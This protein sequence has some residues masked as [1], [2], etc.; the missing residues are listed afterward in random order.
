MRTRCWAAILMLGMS[1]ALLFA[2]DECERAEELKFMTKGKT[3]AELLAK[4]GPGDYVDY[5]TVR[6]GA[7]RLSEESH[8]YFP[9]CENQTIFTIRVQ[10]GRIVEQERQIQR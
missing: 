5:G 8:I 6:M 10:G 7:R 1:P 2:A 9:L 4:V 3:L